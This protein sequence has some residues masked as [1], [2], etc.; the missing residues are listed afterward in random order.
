MLPLAKIFQYAFWKVPGYAVF[1]LFTRPSVL[2]RSPAVTWIFTRHYL[3][4]VVMLNIVT[5]PAKILPIRWDPAHGFFVSLTW[6][7]PLFLAFFVLLECLQVFWLMWG[8]V[9]RASEATS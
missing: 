4:V 1:I 8:C 7:R 2:P 6:S 3:L 5:E 9:W